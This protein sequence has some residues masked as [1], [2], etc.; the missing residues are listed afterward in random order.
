MAT[1]TVRSPTRGDWLQIRHVRQRRVLLAAPWGPHPSLGNSGLPTI[2]L[3]AL[4]LGMSRDVLVAAVDDEL[5]AFAVFERD[6]PRYRWNLCWLAAGSLRVDAT[7]EV[8]TELWIALLE[9]GVLRAGD[10]GARRVFAFCHP[11]SAEHH[12]LLATGYVSYA[13]YIVLR[14]HFKLGLRESG[15]VR[16]QHESDL[17]SIHQLYNRTTPR[18]VQFAEA[19]TSD[20]WVTD[21]ESP[22]P[23][24]NR[25]RFGFVVPTEDGIGAACH[26]DLGSSRP[27][28]TLLCDH[29]LTHAVPSIVADS[30]DH[31]SIRRDVDVV[32]PGYQQE[33]QN[34]LINAG[35]SVIDEIIGTVRHTTVSVVKE[36]VVSD[37][38][39]LSDARPAVT[40]PY[41]GLSL[42]TRDSCQREGS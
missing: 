31:A 5:C 2:S 25:S 27:T 32:L 38:L 36:P 39:T 29:R 28:V 10:A 3:P 7:D 21:D 4:G 24:R 35:F 13:S 40:V 12:S 23:F 15:H 14:G 19:L 42:A 16:E 11:D 20:A 22:I 6:E 37:I 30:L 26:I 33:L 9:E 8:A 41:R 34:P 18:P 1:L 17:W